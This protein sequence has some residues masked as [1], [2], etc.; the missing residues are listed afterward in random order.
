MSLAYGH[1]VAGNDFAKQLQTLFLAK[2]AAQRHQPVIVVRLDP[3]F[4][5]PF[6]M[7]QLVIGFRNFSGGNDFGVV[8]T[9]EHHNARG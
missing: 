7:Q 8:G 3:E 4:A 5:F 2:R 6:W 1:S 9:G